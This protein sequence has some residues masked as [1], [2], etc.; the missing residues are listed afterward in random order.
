M[1]LHTMV[2]FEDS[3]IHLDGNR[4]ANCTFVRC[5]LVFSAT[6]MTALENCQLQ[7]TDFALDGAATT[8]IEFLRGIYHGFGESGPMLARSLWQQIEDPQSAK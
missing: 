3:E 6:E 8:T 2:R 1:T 4:F 5:K 7:D